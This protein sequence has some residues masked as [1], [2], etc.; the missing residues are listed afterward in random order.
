MEPAGD[1]WSRSMARASLE[2][3]NPAYR[4]VRFFYLPLH[5]Y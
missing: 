2:V 3:Q 4:S 1:G 5:P